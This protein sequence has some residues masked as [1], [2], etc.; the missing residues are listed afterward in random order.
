M[1][2]RCGFFNSVNNDRKYNAEDMGRLFEGVISDGV[3]S[4]VES[5]FEIEPVPQTMNLLVNNGKAWFHERYFEIYNPETVTIRTTNINSRIDAICI[6]INTNESVRAGSI[7]VVEGSEAEEPSKPDMPIEDG[8]YYIPIAWVTI[9]GN[10]NVSTNLDITSNIGNATD[11]IESYRCPYSE[12]SLDPRRAVY[13]Y[14]G[15]SEADPHLSKFIHI[16]KSFQ[17]TQSLVYGGR[18]VR[19]FG[20]IT[21]TASD[22]GI[23]EI[24]NNVFVWATVNSISDNNISI[25][26]TTSGV[27]TGLPLKIM[28]YSDN[29]AYV[30]H[31]SVSKMDSNESPDAQLPRFGS[32]GTVS[33][34][35]DIYC[36]KVGA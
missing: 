1:S 5:K 36:I 25:Y 27:Y 24:N 21:V 34:E 4:S 2:I 8:V 16:T 19:K 15:D 30:I 10:D 20:S 28:K 6:C 18:A 31:A 22:L 29:S 17:L 23:D 33:V 3:F 12:P 14:E 9:E 35:I 11:P 32:L 7:E 26:G 13:A